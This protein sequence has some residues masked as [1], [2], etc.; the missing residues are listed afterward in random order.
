MV[1]AG[2]Y[3]LG[4]DYEDEVWAVADLDLEDKKDETDQ[5][6]LAGADLVLAHVEDTR[7][8]VSVRQNRLRHRDCHSKNCRRFPLQP[9]D[10]Y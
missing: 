1:Y 10:P 7:A 6:D 9:R 5:F 8:Q 3:G 4:V 2:S